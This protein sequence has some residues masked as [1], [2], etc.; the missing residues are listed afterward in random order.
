MA[1][2]ATAAAAFVTSPVERAHPST[3][4]SIRRL[5]IR[6]DHQKLGRCTA[7]TTLTV[8]AAGLPVNLCLRLVTVQSDSL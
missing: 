3:Q 4:L 1:A 7:Q 6:P 5:R 8:Q 2:C